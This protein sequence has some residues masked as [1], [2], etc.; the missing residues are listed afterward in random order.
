MAGRGLS[1]VMDND[2]QQR[3]TIDYQQVSLKIIII[4]SVKHHYLKEYI[5][6]Y[7]GIYVYVI[8][9]FISFL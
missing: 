1:E 8:F 6:F 3:S 4:Y 7:I 5:L 2:N 9:Y